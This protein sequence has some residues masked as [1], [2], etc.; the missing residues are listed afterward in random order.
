MFTYSGF[1]YTDYGVNRKRDSVLFLLLRSK[2]TSIVDLSN[3][4]DGAQA[5][6]DTIW[7][8]GS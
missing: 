6:L 7:T 2:G 8:T 4:S 1:Y 3:A 5:M